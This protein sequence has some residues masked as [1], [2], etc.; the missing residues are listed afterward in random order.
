[1]KMQSIRCCA[2]SVEE[3]VRSLGSISTSDPFK[4]FMKGPLVAES[5]QLKFDF[6]PNRASALPPEV[7]IGL[8]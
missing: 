4:P 7:V 5:G 6:R 8:E 3:L 1:M 2:F